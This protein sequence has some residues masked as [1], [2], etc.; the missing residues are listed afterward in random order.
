[1]PILSLFVIQA[2]ILH[3]PQQIPWTRHP[4]PTPYPVILH[5]W[6]RHE[7]NKGIHGHITRFRHP[8]SPRVNVNHVHPLHNDSSDIVPSGHAP[9]M[10][11]IIDDQLQHSCTD[12]ANINLQALLFSLSTPGVDQTY[13][14]DP[15][16]ER[17]CVDTGASAFISTKKNNFITLKSV[18]DLNKWDWHWTSY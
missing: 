14:F 6:F 16:I 1:M 13:N 7:W 12:A 17:I 18:S 4:P 5:N 10:Y 8:G 9:D 2:I 11:S 3:S 15:T